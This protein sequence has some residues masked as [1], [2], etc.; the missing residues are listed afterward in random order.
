MTDYLSRLDT[1]LAAHG[2]NQ[3]AVSK[4]AGYPGVIAN[5]RREDGDERQSPRHNTLKAVADAAHADPG[6]MAYDETPVPTAAMPGYHTKPMNGLS[7]K[8]EIVRQVW[9]DEGLGVA[10]FAALERTGLA[11]GIYLIGVED[12]RLTYDHIG[13]LAGRMFGFG[14]W[15]KAHRKFVGEVDPDPEFAY[16]CLRDY[17]DSYDND[18]VRMDDCEATSFYTGE[19]LGWK[20]LRL[21][22]PCEKRLLIVNEVVI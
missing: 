5:W 17:R 3:T 21:I 13:W 10:L 15:T 4:A 7:P 22:L 19:G 6:W 11:K 9:D 18:L 14:W 2:M 12:H 20:W 16:G 1:A 8:M